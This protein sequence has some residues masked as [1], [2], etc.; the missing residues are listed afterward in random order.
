MT[1]W[2]QRSNVDWIGTLV[3]TSSV[4]AVACSRGHA[5]AGLDSLG[6]VTT[7]SNAPDTAAQFSARAAVRSDAR[8][9]RWDAEVAPLLAAQ[10]VDVDALKGKGLEALNEALALA[11]DR[12][13]QAALTPR[14]AQRTGAL[15]VL[16]AFAEAL[17]RGDEQRALTVLEGVPAEPQGDVPAVSHVIGT[18]A[19]LLDTWFAHPEKQ[20]A[21]AATRVSRRGNKLARAVATDLLG[22]ARRGRSFVSL[23][24]LRKRYNGLVILEGAALAVAA[25]TTAVAVY[26]AEPVSLVLGRLVAD[27]A[28]M[29]ASTPLSGARSAGA[30]SG[31]SFARPGGAPASFT[32][33]PTVA[34]GAIPVTS[35]R[36]ERFG[37]WLEQQTKI[38]APSVQAELEM[39]RSIVE[40][41]DARGLDLEQP[42]DIEFVV[43]LLD[44]MANEE[45][46]EVAHNAL[47]TLDDYLHYR[48]VGVGGEAWESAHRAIEA[49][50][51]SETPTAA[52][53]AAPMLGTVL[54]AAQAVD[55]GERL[56][57]LIGLRV[58]AGVSEVLDW[59]GR[60]KEIAEDGSLTDADLA[61]LAEMLG[62]SGVREWW[63]ALAYTG[64]IETGA[65][66]ARRGPQAGD[67][68]AGDTPPVEL[69]EKLVTI[70][71]AETLTAPLRGATDDTS[72]TLV[73][74]VIA[75]MLGLLSPD[76][77][78]TPAQ[79]AAPAS[80]EGL[81]ASALIMPND[82][83]QFEVP[84]RLRGAV[85][86]GTLLA[87]EILTGEGPKAS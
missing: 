78:E 30:S 48:L 86:R 11:A 12:H 44:E 46:P 43:G 57:A 69:A 3:V 42:D 13:K 35:T 25:A 67:W 15:V 7:S 38:A 47:A 65:S 2:R 4:S 60:S 22:L 56:A 52:P 29:V 9:Q 84:E 53:V 26:E 64:I 1:P 71:V 10:G 6:H 70:F 5:A 50:L 34:R 83:G 72:K 40:L 61:R 17:D 74:D 79:L 85:A 59:I 80:L 24:G 87:M 28:A 55:P 23:D 76:Q 39:F 49:A 66:R 45:K 54:A 81:V 51:G 33:P 62:S 20:P 77:E 75:K 63:T 21:L 73:A 68:A 32:S 19:S 82:A 58:V 16:R 14:G 31:S 37:A 18:A 41:A 36:A 8:E 27:D